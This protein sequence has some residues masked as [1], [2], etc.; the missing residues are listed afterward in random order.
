MR[1]AAQDDSEAGEEAEAEAES[2]RRR[3]PNAVDGV[4]RRI[5][6]DRGRRERDLVPSARLTPTATTFRSSA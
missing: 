1:R 5:T 3:D 6:V 2:L 4:R